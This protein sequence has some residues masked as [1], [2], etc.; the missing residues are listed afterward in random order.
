MQLLRHRLTWGFSCIDRT[1]VKRIFVLGPSHH[2]H[3]EHCALPKRG[4]TVY[5]TPLGDIEL[6]QAVL[7]ELRATGHTQGLK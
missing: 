6:D 5:E 4:V 3:L 1:V 7:D 2:I